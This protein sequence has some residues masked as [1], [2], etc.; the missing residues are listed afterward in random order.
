MDEINHQQAERDAQ[1][2][3]TLRMHRRQL[4]RVDCVEGAQQIQLTVV[5]RCR[6]AQ[7]RHLNIHPAQ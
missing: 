6:I 1:R 3:G 4:L 2:D 5:V 7:D